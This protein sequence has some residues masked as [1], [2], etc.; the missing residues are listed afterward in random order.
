MVA[1]LAPF[2][3]PANTVFIIAILYP[4]YSTPEIASHFYSQREVLAELSDDHLYLNLEKEWRIPRNE[5]IEMSFKQG[6]FPL[7]PSRVEVLT[8]QG[9]TVLRTHI[10]YVPLMKFLR[11]TTDTFRQEQKPVSR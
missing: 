2:S 3:L 4:L 11:K 5:I 7:T 9:E 6:F 8:N 1:L 10:H